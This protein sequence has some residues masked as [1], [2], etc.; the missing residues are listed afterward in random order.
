M[1]HAS[2]CAAVRKRQDFMDRND[3][4]NWMRMANAEQHELFREII[5]RRRGRGHLRYGTSSPDRPVA[6]RRSSFGLPLTSTTGIATPAATPP[7]MRS[8]SARAPERRLWQWEE[9]RCTRISSS[10]GR[11]SAPTRTEASA[12]A[13]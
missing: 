3:Y 2:L 9:P 11:P 4:Y 1:K 12:P 8:S 7:K 6:A 5:H 10:L 13:S